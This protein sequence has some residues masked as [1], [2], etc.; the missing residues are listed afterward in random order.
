V[1]LLIYPF[2]LQKQFEYYLHLRGAHSNLVSYKK[3]IEKIKN[4]KKSTK[5]YR[6]CTLYM[7]NCF[8]ASTFGYILIRGAF[9]NY[10][11]DFLVLHLIS[12]TPIFLSQLKIQRT[13]KGH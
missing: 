12:I 11:F 3:N 2:I 13:K 8:L 9:Y 4:D 5:Y 7:Y 6:I 10:F 1:L